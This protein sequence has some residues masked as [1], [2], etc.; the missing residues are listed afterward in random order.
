MISMEIAVIVIFAFL[1]IAIL[2][3]RPLIKIRRMSSVTDR[4]PE[5]HKPQLTHNLYRHVRALAH[6][7]GSRS[8]SE[9]DKLKEAQTYIETVLRES[10]IP[11]SIQDCPAHEKTCANIV[12]TFPGSRPLPQKILIGAHYDTIPGTPGAD[13]NASSVSVL[14]EMCRALKNST[15]DKT[16]QLVFFTLEEPP[17]FDT[18][19]MGSRVC[20]GEARKNNEDILLMIC[21]EMIG[22]YSPRKNGQEFP[23]PLMNLFYSAVPDFVLVAGDLA[24]RKMV[25]FAGDCIRRTSG[26]RVETLTVPQCFP[27][28]KLSDHSSFW[29]RGYRAIMITDTAF[30]R[31]PNY[32]TPMDTIDTLDFKAMTALCETLI[33]MVHEL[34]GR[35]D[36]GNCR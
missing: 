5:P 10:G 23:L 24:S 34:D 32:H 20:A 19:R 11:Y 22:Y 12:V 15:P 18:E 27:G 21:L 9:Y 28:I 2:M 31:N 1:A 4:A 25:A 29:R 6:Q 36:D 33:K 14:L 3:A 35:P 17:S 26:L 7:I 13:D 8:L 16:L 30:Y